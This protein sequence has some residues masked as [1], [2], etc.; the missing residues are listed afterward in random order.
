MR[1]SGAHRELSVRVGGA[2]SFRIQKK[3]S[4]QERGDPRFK[5]KSI[6]YKVKLDY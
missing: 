2:K 1:T 4:K 6:R 5:S 3:S